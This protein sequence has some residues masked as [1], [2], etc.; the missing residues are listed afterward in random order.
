MKKIAPVFAVLLVTTIVAAQPKTNAPVFN[1][2]SVPYGEDWSCV[3]ARAEKVDRSFSVCYR[4]HEACMADIAKTKSSKEITV[5]SECRKQAKVSAFTYFSP[6]KNAYILDASATI[7]ECEN[8]QFYAVKYGGE[9]K[10]GVSP[11]QLVG[12]RAFETARMSEFVN[13]IPANA[14]YF[15]YSTEVATKDVFSLCSTSLRECKESYDGEDTKRV[16]PCRRMKSVFVY[17]SI[18]GGE[19][20]FSALGTIKTCEQFRR[21]SFERSDTTGIS[22]CVEVK[23]KR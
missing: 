21:W 8:D 3:G 17:N 10:R 6:T 11:C 19:G 15:C 1:Y 20:F 16:S 5:T 14:K 13:G 2:E 9:D 4:T 7:S 23:L 22:P 18:Q 12:A